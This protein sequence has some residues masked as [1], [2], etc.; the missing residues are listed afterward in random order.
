MGDDDERLDFLDLHRKNIST[1]MNEVPSCT[2][3]AL[4]VLDELL[5]AITE[6]KESMNDQLAHKKE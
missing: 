4:E 6:L 1:I 5:I 3:E 2:E